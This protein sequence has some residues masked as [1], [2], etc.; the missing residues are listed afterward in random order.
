MALAAGIVCFVPSFA[1]TD[2]SSPRHSLIAE[3]IDASFLGRP[4]G[5][6]E[7]WP[8][9]NRVSFGGFP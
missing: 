3:D 5:F 9:L 4:L 8:F 2:T 6:G 7:G 1:V